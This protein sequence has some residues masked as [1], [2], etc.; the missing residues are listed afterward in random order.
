MD[1]VMISSVPGSRVACKD[2]F[3]FVLLIVKSFVDGRLSG[4][5]DENAHSSSSAAGAGTFAE[6]E[7]GS[8]GFAKSNIE[9]DCCGVDCLDEDV[10]E[11]NGS[12]FEGGGLEAEAC[13]CC[14]CCC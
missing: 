6:C 10:R 1:K 13:C 4:K 8:L 14:C 11:A 5:A 12:R 7:T 9:P 3:R 2:M